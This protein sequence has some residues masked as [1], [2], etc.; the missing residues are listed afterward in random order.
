MI[1][2]K[3]IIDVLH[4]IGV[5]NERW[6]TISEYDNYLISDQGYVFSL[7][8]AKPM[9]P[10]ETDKGYLRVPLR[11]ENGIKKPR[12]H[13]LVAEAFISNPEG[14]SQVDHIDG[15]KHH[16]NYKNLRYCTNQENQIAAVQKGS[17]KTKTNKQAQYR[18]KKRQ[19]A[20]KEKEFKEQQERNN[21]LTAV[22]S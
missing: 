1:L 7:N 22:S 9:A 12:L 20:F 13:R 2:T 17:H 10:E 15:V 19:E 6:S 18:L 5:D 8:S 16:N 3:K 11:N 21:K 4:A 14:K